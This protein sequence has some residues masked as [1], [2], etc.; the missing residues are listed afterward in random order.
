MRTT[1]TVRIRPRAAKG[2]QVHVWKWNSESKDCD[3]ASL[4]ETS[5]AGKVARKLESGECLP[6]EDWLWLLDAVNTPLSVPRGCLP[7]LGYSFDFRPYLRRYVYYQYGRWSEYYA[8]NRTLLR[9]S[10][11]GG[12]AIRNI[13]EVI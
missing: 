5:R 7:L 3:I 11:Y 9:K 8:P 4:R 1:T 12:S 13:V 6:L 10:L 2:V